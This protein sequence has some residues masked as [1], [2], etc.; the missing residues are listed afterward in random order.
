[1]NTLHR[2]LPDEP[3]I[4]EEL[5]QESAQVPRWG[6][7][8]V[9]EKSVPQR[10]RRGGAHDA[11]W[12]NLVPLRGRGEGHMLRFGGNVVLRGAEGKGATAEGANRP[13]YKVTRCIDDG[14]KGLQPAEP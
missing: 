6:A 8:N 14:P 5:V 4:V 11:F 13:F 12:K 1:M 3:L 9:S 2:R 7:D 10:G